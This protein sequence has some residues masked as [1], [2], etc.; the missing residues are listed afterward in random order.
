MAE[1]EVWRTQNL[2]QFLTNDLEKRVKRDKPTK[3]S[4]F[5]TGLSAY[6]PE[7]MNLFLKGESGVGK[8]YNVVETLKYFSQEDVWF[9]GALSPKALI[10]SYG[11]L[12][13]AEGEPLD[14]AKKPL[15][16][17]RKDFR[18]DFGEFKEIEFTEANERYGEQLKAWSE[19]IRNSYTLIDLSHKILVF[20]EAPEWETYRMLLPILS[21][22][23]NRIEYR[24]TDKSA[25]GQL[26]TLKVV[27]EGWPATIFLT[28]DRK[29][30]E[31]LATRSF[32][33]TPEASKEKIE[34]ANI[35]TNLKASV[36]W[37]YAVETQE[38][39]VIKALI[40]SL[41]N[42]FL[43]AETDIVIPFTNL[44][45]L[46]PKVIVRD[47]RDFQHFC[48]F[49]KT[50]TA[51]YTYQRPSFKI[52]DKRFIVSNVEDV[53]QALEIY[54]YLFESTRTGTEEKTLRFYHDI[55]KT[56]E[57]WYLQE[58]TAKYNEKA[59]RKVSS[60]WVK[61]IMQRLSD[62]GYVTVEADSEDRRLNLYKP[63]LKEEKEK[64]EIHRYLDS[65]VILIHK[66][67]IGLEN[68][69]KN[70]GFG[71]DFYYYKN[72]SEKEWSEALISME[73]AFK[74]ILGEKN[75]VSNM[76][77]SKNPLIL[78]VQ[79]GLESEKKA[80]I[81]G[82][83]DYRQSSSNS[84]FTKESKEEWIAKREG[85]RITIK[86]GEVMFQCPYCEGKGKPMFFATKSDLE[87]HVQKVHGIW[88]SNYVR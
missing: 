23:T 68:W 59:L 12:L 22:D 62:I 46:F 44:Y 78:S 11:V 83:S 71:K 47:M 87:G 67:E 48:Q 34:E 1:V 39:E 27:I 79:K 56:K 86:T 17:K 5:F 15:K 28:I 60:D 7:P 10:H 55:V 84:V 63:L 57:A 69:R 52:N 82:E 50:I 3:L 40:L 36:P 72:F 41:K 81:R 42:Q 85:N 76:E 77:A 51:L 4:V 19:E 80:E 37:Q 35:L 13:N 43:K 58:L 73:E 29:Y 74:L 21:H 66:L 54:S 25:K 18:D 31:E 26:R 20:L 33:V 61:K 6:L 38:A 30:M 49:L 24:F 53:R 16:P 2:L 65:P 9:L 14:L 70:I 8:S 32:T 64:E 45:E 75:F 88:D